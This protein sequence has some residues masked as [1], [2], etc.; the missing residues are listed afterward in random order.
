MDKESSVREIDPENLRKRVLRSLRAQGFSIE[1]GEI[2]LRNP[3]DKAAIRQAH[4][5]AVAHRIEQAR[6]GLERHEPRLLERIA[7]GTEVDPAHLLPRLI[8]VLPNS[9][10]ELLFRY[11]RLHWSIPVSA[12][13]GR[14]IRFLVI[15]EYNGKLIGILGLGDPVFALGPRDRWIGWTQDDRRERIR[16][17]MDAFVLGAVPPYSHLL[18]GKLVALLA[19]S[20]EVRQAV[21]RKYGGRHT[22]ING[23]A[24]DGRLALVTTTSALGRSSLYNRLRLDGRLVFR[25]VGFTRGS[26][27]FH[28]TNG[29]YQDLRAFAEQHCIATAKDSRWGTGFRNR[30]EIIRKALPALGLKRDL[31]YHGVQREIFVAPLAHNTR[32]FLRGEHSRLRWFH[33]PAADLFEAFRE[34]WLLPRALRD[35]RYREFS[36]DSYRLWHR[37]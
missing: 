18:C 23:D 8:E 36:R 4:A 3:T 32:E 28:F 35:A 15:D 20:D 33:R 12:G 21:K 1:R 27:E 29:V 25:N 22:L 16:A 9:E 5:L 14:R 30:R 7:N 19:T 11:A 2:A 31:I 24:H 34:R 26:G 13:Y 10:E 17:V 6:A 37:L